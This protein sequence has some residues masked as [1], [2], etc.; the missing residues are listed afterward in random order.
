MGWFGLGKPRTKFGSWLDQNGIKQ[1][2]F[3][4]MSGLGRNTVSRLANDDQWMPERK[5]A[6]RVMEAVNEIDEDK[7][8]RDFWE[9]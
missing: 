5:T 4:E 8:T 6:N 1:S 2:D 7:T 3:S 9:W